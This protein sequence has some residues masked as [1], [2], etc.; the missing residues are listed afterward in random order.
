MVTGLHPFDRANATDVAWQ[1]QESALL[2]SWGDNL[3]HAGL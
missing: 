3:C 1:Q 2:L